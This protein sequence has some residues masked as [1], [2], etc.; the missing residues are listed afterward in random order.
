MNESSI[1]D[2]RSSNCAAQW[3]LTAT[4]CCPLVMKMQK[5]PLAGL[6]TQPPTVALKMEAQSEYAQVAY[7]FFARSAPI[8]H[9]RS[10]LSNENF[11]TRSSGR[12]LLRVRCCW[13]GVE[14]QPEQKN[15]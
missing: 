2:S 4:A 13:L 7:T 3:K 9:A 15:I 8:S 12:S 5:N 11:C 14:Q 6:R 1:Y 10:A